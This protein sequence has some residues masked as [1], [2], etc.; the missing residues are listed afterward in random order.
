VDD[1][2]EYKTRIIDDYMADILI[3]RERKEREKK[4]AISL[5]TKT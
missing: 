5:S 4:R 2:Y 1:C 3:E